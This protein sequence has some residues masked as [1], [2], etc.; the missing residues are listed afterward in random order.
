MKI[1]IVELFRDTSDNSE[2]EHPMVTDLT[3]HQI[4]QLNYL[5]IFLIILS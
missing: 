2:L 4:K 5:G 3:D 1:S